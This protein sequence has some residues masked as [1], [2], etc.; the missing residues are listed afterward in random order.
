M[1]AAA[2]NTI[3]PLRTPQAADA[4]HAVAVEQV[5]HRVLRRRTIALRC[6]T[7]ELAGALRRF[8]ERQAEIDAGQWETTIRMPAVGGFAGF[9]AAA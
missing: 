8:R 9:A 7:A 1:S 6:R 4:T 5:L 3:R 2:T